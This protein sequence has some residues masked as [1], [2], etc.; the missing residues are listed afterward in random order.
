MWSS[1]RSFTIESI[2][3][4]SESAKSFYLAPSNGED[5]CPYLPGQHLP[6][7][8]KIPGRSSPV[9]R[10]YTLSDCYRG[11]PYR[12]TIKREAPPA[13]HPTAPSGLSST[14]FHDQLKIGDQIE[15]KMPAGNFF[16]DLEKPHPVALIAGGIGVTPM[17]SMLNA[18]SDS[19]LSRV[20]YFIF[21]L[22][23]GGDHVFKRHLRYLRNRFSNMHMHIL[24][25]QPRPEDRLQIDF[26][27]TGLV[28]LSLLK[29]IL[30]TLS[31]EYYLCGPP[32]MMKS[33]S[34]ELLEQGVPAANIKTESFGPSSI[35][36][37][38]ARQDDSPETIQVTF[39]R[40][41]T[42][43]QWPSGE[44]KTLLELA[45]ANGIDLAYGCR[46]GDCATCQ[47]RLVS[48]TVQYRHKTKARPDTGTCL[49]CCC[50]PTTSVVL[51]A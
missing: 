37:L 29:R 11:A 34:A 36:L 26:D 6:I 19:G 35:S 8:L 33:V 22:R 31:I 10:C 32:G 51:D 46:Y 28:N 4:E 17:I 39:L 30:P 48:G 42:I 40:S 2:V 45:E 43:V 14:F 50:R 16:L 49:P 41:G 9:I 47:T 15:A 18:L 24:Y 27:E 44:S 3:V 12:L 20:V 7:R 25:D 13:A 5:V 23:H 1:Y 21:A 38:T